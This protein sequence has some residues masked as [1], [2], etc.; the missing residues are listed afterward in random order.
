MILV[1]LGFGP[2]TKVVFFDYS[3]AALRVRKLLIEEW[4]GDDFPR[5][6]KRLFQRLPEPEAFYQMWPGATPESIDWGDIEQLWEGE[7]RKWGGAHAFRTHWE[8]YRRLGHEFIECDVLTEP[9]KVFAKVAPEANS[10]VWW[11]NAFFTVYGNWHGTPAQ[12]W[13]SYERWV[14]GLAAKGPG[15]FL[16]GADPDNVSVNDVRAAAYLGQLREHRRDPLVPRKPCK[17]AIRT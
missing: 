17:H 8:E 16:Y 5:F 1:S 14:A 11:S 2:E 9:E 7:T 10:V 4:D 15:M 12:C 3:P 13:R 6:V